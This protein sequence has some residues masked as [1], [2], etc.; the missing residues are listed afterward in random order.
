VSEPDHDPPGRRDATWYLTP[1]ELQLLQ[2]Y[3]LGVRVIDLPGSR[4]SVK[5]HLK[6]ARRKFG[7]PTT[8]HVACEALRRGL[9]H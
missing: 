7:L 4:E 5:T 3:S 6:Y 9:I 1:T 2:T 8:G